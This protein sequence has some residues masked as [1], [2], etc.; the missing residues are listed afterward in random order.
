MDFIVKLLRLK[1]FVIKKEYNVILVRV[2][3]FIKYSNIILFKNK[4]K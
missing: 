1:N 4:I 2:N 3:R